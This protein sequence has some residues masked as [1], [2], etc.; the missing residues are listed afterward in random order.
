MQ[1]IL[2]DK[3]YGTNHHRYGHSEEI[4]YLKDLGKT[5]YR[6]DDP[7]FNI[8]ADKIY[9]A[10]KAYDRL[11]KNFYPGYQDRSGDFLAVWDWY[12]SCKG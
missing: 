8:I 10:A 2:R 3:E 5:S 9:A 4:E 6:S 11:S 7:A 1:M 12:E